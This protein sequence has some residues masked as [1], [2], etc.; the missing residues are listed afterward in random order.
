MRSLRLLFLILCFLLGAYLWFLGR[1]PTE[2]AEPERRT[3]GIVVLTGGALRLDEAAALLADGR[4][5]RLLV[6]G[7]STDTQPVDIR[8]RMAGVPDALFQCCVDLGYRA[9]NT[10]GNADE[11]AAWARSHGMTSLRV[12]TAAYHMP[13]SLVE[14]R[15]ALPGVELVAHP[16]FPERVFQSG[17][18]PPV[19]APLEFAKFVAA[20]IRLRLSELEPESQREVVAP[21]APAASPPVQP[22]A[23]SSVLPA[24]PEPPK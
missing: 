13:R 11:A 14:L 24:A 17:S 9:R 6:S 20:L 18:L 5:G 7:V 10:V 8:E 1:I 4:A 2:V 15:R 22:S 3:D 21:L 23:P 12:V 16:V 19:T